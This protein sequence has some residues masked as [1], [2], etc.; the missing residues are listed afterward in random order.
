MASLPEKRPAGAHYIV[1]SSMKTEHDAR[2]PI[3]PDSP[4]L[5]VI[6]YAPK[7]AV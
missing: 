2:Y 1:D 6:K 7:G 4:E 5:P 3:Y